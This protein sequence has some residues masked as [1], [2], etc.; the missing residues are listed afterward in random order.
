MKV[1]IAA[2]DLERARLLRDKI[3]ALP[4]VTCCARW[5]TEADP[6]KF[7]KG[8]HYPDEEREQQALAC[9]ADVLAA[10]V[11]VSLGE[12]SMGKGGR[13][14]ELGIAL[15]RLDLIGTPN[16]YHIGYP[17]HVFHWYPEVLLLPCDDDFVATLFS[18]I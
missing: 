3:E 1:Y 6:V 14:V 15:A 7:G 2:R 11:F 9:Y 10:N 16:C 17:E 18:E 4:G 8:H 5:I 13:H 12:E